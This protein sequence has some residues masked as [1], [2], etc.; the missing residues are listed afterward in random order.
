MLAR[1]ESAISIRS[2]LEYNEQ[3]VEEHKALLLD[4]HNFLQEKEELTMRDKRDRFQELT[5]RNERS[6]KKIV[7]LSVNFPVEDKLDDR[8][9]VRI[10]TEFMQGIGFGDQP[11]LLYRHLDAGHP[12]F[13]IVTTNIRPDG[14]RISSDFRSPHHLMRV[15]FGIEEKHGL[16]PALAM[17]DLFASGETQAPEQGSRYQLQVYRSSD[18]AALRPGHANTAETRNAMLRL[19]GQHDTIVE[20]KLAEQ[21]RQ[22]QVMNQ[23]YGHSL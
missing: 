21:Q 13:H 20:Q 23:S 6:Q 14:S 16:T 3:K 12:H 17:P 4:A 5:V 11:W 15:C 18:E 1:T 7:H 9:M 2:P 22:A 19:S 10:G 8:Q